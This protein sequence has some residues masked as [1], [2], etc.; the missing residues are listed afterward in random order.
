MAFLQA[1][2]TSTRKPICVKMLLSPPCSQMPMV[3]ASTDSGTIRMIA[4][5]SEK[6]SYCAASTRNTNN[7]HSGKTHS[8]A[9]P[10][11]IC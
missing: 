5:G 6:L 10:E 2:A 9:S 4:S 3:P 8:A 1:S 11:A 7:T